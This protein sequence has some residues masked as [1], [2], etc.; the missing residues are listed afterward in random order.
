M[1]LLPSLK[2][3][4]VRPSPTLHSAVVS[5]MIP[6][7]EIALENPSSFSSRRRAGLARKLTPN[8]LASMSFPKYFLL[9]V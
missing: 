1:N 2:T 5:F 9:T 3:V 6:S 8:S 7:P 4:S